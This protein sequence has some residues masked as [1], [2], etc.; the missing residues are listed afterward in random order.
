MQLTLQKLQVERDDLHKA[1]A[2][3]DA[4]KAD[5]VAKFDQYGGHLQE[6]H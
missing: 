4:E 5:I 2:D 1:I 6:T 3:G